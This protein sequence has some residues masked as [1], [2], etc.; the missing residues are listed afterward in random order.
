ME[1]RFGPVLTLMEWVTIYRI[2]KGLPVLGVDREATIE[3]FEKVVLVKVESQ[4][5]ATLSGFAE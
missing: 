4:T 1:H 5:Y 3:K 2:L